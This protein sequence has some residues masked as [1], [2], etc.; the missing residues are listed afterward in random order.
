MELRHLFTFQTIVK[1]GSFLKAAEK[2]Q[3]AQS[4]ITLHIQQLEAELGVQLF[5]RRG[6]RV[7]LTEAGRALEEQAEHL[8]ARA[9]ALQQAMED[10]VA[11]QAGQLRV[12]AIEPMASLRLAPLVARYCLAHPQVNMILEVGSKQSLSQRVADGAL[13]VAV[14]PPPAQPGLDFEFLFQEEMALLLPENHPLTMRQALEREELNDERLLLT[15]DGCVYREFLDAELLRRGISVSANVSVGSLHA[16]VRLVQE[17]LGIAIVPVSLA[18][19]L[20]MKTALR[21]LQGVPLSLPIGLVRPADS[22]PG[23]AL[24]SLLHQLRTELRTGEP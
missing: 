1:E 7:Q 10:V 23:R 14:C 16:L 15:G 19:P 2:L 8:L 3:Y 6:K 20:P 13:D 5:V 11:G 12:G 18:S 17:G 22:S 21:T 4:T 9:R 24:R